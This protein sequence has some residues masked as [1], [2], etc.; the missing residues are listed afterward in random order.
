MS[1]EENADCSC[2]DGKKH[3]HCYPNGKT[4]GPECSGRGE[5]SCGH[6][7]CDSNPDPENPTKVRL[8]WKNKVE[9]IANEFTTHSLKLRFELQ[10]AAGWRPTARRLCVIYRYVMNWWFNA[11]FV[12]WN[13]NHPQLQNETKPKQLTL[14]KNKAAVATSTT[15]SGEA[16]PP[17]LRWQC[18]LSYLS[19]EIP[20]CRRTQLISV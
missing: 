2:A 10:R 11:Y 13:Q 3:L 19:A 18:G 4:N 7:I 5:C 14:N 20:V 12:V 1:L 16:S 6:C 15:G 9:W 17:L 8:F